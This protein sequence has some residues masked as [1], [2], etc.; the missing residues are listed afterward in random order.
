MQ[1]AFVVGCMR[2]ELQ[3]QRYRINDDDDDDNDNSGG[4]LVS[5]EKTFGE[6]SGVSVRGNR[7][8]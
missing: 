3:Q 1:N 8:N 7:K 4:G 5:D 6:T 2:R